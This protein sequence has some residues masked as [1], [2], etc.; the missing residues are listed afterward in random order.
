MR[1][2]LGLVA[3]SSHCDL[4][5]RSGDQR[6]PGR[7]VEGHR[8]APTRLGNALWPT[9]VRFVHVLSWVGDASY[10][11]HRTGNGELRLLIQRGGVRN[12][13]WVLLPRP[14]PELH[15]RAAERDGVD[16]GL[17]SRQCAPHRPEGEA[18]SQADQDD[19][20][21]EHQPWH[22]DHAFQSSSTTSSST[23][24]RGL[25]A[26]EDREI[27]P[28]ATATA[29]SRLR[30]RQPSRGISSRDV[31]AVATPGVRKLSCRGQSQALALRAVP[32]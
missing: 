28:A 8:R 22:H 6:R 14:T 32:R 30:A 17:P 20:P 9:Q 23:R 7:L 19:L 27:S 16:Q 18:A 11:D 21:R 15:D 29:R 5:R 25:G 1:K 13:Y 26:Y 12:P 4:V 2:V 24:G 10:R 3:R 31:R